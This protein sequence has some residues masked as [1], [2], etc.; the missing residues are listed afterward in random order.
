MF[1]TRLLSGIVLVAGSGTSDYYQW[2]LC[3]VFYT[4][5]DLSDRNAGAL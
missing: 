1:K 2:R 4:A 3:A 5:W